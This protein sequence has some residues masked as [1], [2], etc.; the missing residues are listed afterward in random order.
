MLA[1]TARRPRPVTPT[2]LAGA[3]RHLA[4]PLRTCEKDQQD[5][6]T[7][8]PGDGVTGLARRVV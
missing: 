4:I 7:R 8:I 3:R 6:C 2:E 5:L 1:H